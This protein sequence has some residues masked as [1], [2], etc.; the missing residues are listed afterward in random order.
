MTPLAMPAAVNDTLAYSVNKYDMVAGMGYLTASGNTSYNALL[1]TPG[2]V[3]FYGLTAGVTDL[4]TLAASVLPAGWVLNTARGIND[5]GEIV[6]TGTYNGNSLAYTLSLPQAIPGDANLDGKV[7][8]N[9][10]TIVLSHFGQTTGVSWGTGDFNGDGRV[11]VNDL[12]IVLSNFGESVSTSI[13]GS[14][15]AVPE[16]GS[17][18]LAV[19]AASACW[20]SPTASLINGNGNRLVVCNHMIG[21][22]RTTAT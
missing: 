12:T 9:D 20:P 15:S 6:G 8:V 2:V 16:P 14:L 5:S 22:F 18:L 1:W 11:D 17:L 4:N 21:H 13:G 19:L 7:D 3:P 10:L